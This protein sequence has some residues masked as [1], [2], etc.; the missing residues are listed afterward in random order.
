MILTSTTC[1]RSVLRQNSCRQRVLIVCVQHRDSFLHDDG[2]VVEFFVDLCL[3][4]DEVKRKVRIGDPV[5]LVQNW[6]A[7]LKE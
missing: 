7:A 1:W 4:A 3:P 6:A 2:S 5:T